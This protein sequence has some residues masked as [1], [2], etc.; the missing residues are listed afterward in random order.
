MRKRIIGVFIALAL[1]AVLVPV[2]PAGAQ[3]PGP[4]HHVVI[5]PTSATMAVGGTQQFTAQ[6][7]DANNLPIPNLLYVWALVAGGGTL[8]NTGLFTAGNIT[9][10]YT[11][12]VQVIAVQNGTIKIAYASVTINA[13]GPLHHV[14]ITPTSATV[15]AGGKKQFTA[16]GQDANNVLIPNLTYV[17]ALVAG[18]GTLSN[19]GLFTA[20]NI[21]GTYTNTVQVVAVQGSTIKTA[22]ASVTVTTTTAPKQ[23]C[24][25]PGW[26]KGKKTGWNGHVPPGWCKG[27]KSGWQDDMPPGWSKWEKIGCQ[28]C[29]HP[30]WCDRCDDKSE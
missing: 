23:I 14:V 2:L 20:G 27:K 19:A 21:A 9:G 26:C 5:T 11:N 8:S 12:T 17:W 15:K 29:L 24:A 25:H 4:L 6:G 13:P 28:D 3:T 7:Q 10:T 18:G 22:Y 1:I 16:Q 30:V